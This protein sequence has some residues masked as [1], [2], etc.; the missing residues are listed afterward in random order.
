MLMSAVL[1]FVSSICHFQ[2]RHGLT[3]VTDMKN[4][5]SNDLK[6]LK[7]Q[8]KSLSMR[9]FHLEQITKSQAQKKV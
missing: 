1:C 4:F 2:K 3:S 5:V 7:Q 8:H 9:K 6:D